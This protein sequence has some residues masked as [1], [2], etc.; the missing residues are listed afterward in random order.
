MGHYRENG[1]SLV[2]EGQSERTK[3]N[4]TSY[5]KGD[6]IWAQKRFPSANGASLGQGP[7]QWGIF[8]CGDCPDLLGHSPEQPPA[9]VT[10]ALLWA[11]AHTKD[12]Q[13]DLQPELVCTKSEVRLCSFVIYLASVSSAVPSIA[14][15]LAG[16]GRFLGEVL[17]LR[18]IKV[19]FVPVL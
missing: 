11:R 5:K 16:T 3:G 1:F 14:V 15:Q 13:E 4:S 18:M 8:I 9:A 10:L 19:S 7:K 12:L 17:E 2:S 6:K